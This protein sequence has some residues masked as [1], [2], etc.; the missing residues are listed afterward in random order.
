MKLTQRMKTAWEMLRGRETK[1]IKPVF[2]SFAP[3]TGEALWRDDPQQQVRMC[4]HWVYVAVRSIAAKVAGTP[5]MFLDEKTG[6]KLPHAH[7][8]PKLFREVNPFE[9]AV[10]LWMKTVMF[11]EL[12]GNAFWYVARNGLGAVAEIWILPSQNMRVLPS[13]TRFIDGYIFR[14]AG[15]E[16]RFEVDEI[17]H[18]KYPSPESQFYG[19]GPLQAAAES[20]DAHAAMKTAERRSFETGAFPGLAIQTDEKLS[21]DVRR[22]LEE[23]FAAGFSGA[24]RAGKTLI[25]E[26]G[27]KVRPFTF[28]PREMDFLES[29]KMTRDEILS[30]FGV[31]AAVAGIAEDV[32]RASAEAMLYTFAENT[33]LPK[34]RMIEA[35]LTQDLCS[36]FSPEIAARFDNP[37][38]AV[39]AE[40]R[41][42]MVARVANGITTP[43]EERARLGLLA[44][45]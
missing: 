40:D 16:E 29:S 30:V 18:L 34:L 6:E 35:Q 13:R 26:Q 22:R 15:V 25:L 12:T 39:R 7:P 21:P 14:N 28:S 11:L 32:N 8:L 23:T 43:D 3:G 38:P 9:T 4:R 27:L 19:V 45:G 41:A 33:I 2:R 10:G 5:I 44:R 37:V 1:S 36:T 24:E 20:V 31:P 42:D 17:I